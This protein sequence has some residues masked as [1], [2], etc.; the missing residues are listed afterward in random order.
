MNKKKDIVGLCLETFV[1]KGLFETSTR[2]L[3]SALQL[4]NAGLYYYFKSKDEAVIACVEEAISILELS[5]ILPSILALSRS[6]CSIE[7]I[8]ATAD[9]MSPLTRFVVQAVSSPTYRELLKPVVNS[10]TNRFHSYSKRFEKDIGCVFDEIEPLIFI[11][12]TAIINYTVFEDET[13][14][15]PQL[16]YIKGKTESLVKD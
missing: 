7:S 8:I 15:K 14:I 9:Q 1:S 16:E 11:F 3:S 6:D 4:Q 13:Y 12:I 2:E 5:L 10:M